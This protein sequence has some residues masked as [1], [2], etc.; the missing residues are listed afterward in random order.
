M[1]ISSMKRAA[2]AA[3]LS[4]TVASF[5]FGARADETALSVNA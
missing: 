1:M 5:G 3:A 4:V 2:V